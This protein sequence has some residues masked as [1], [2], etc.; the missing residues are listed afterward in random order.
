MTFK[1]MLAVLLSVVQVAGLGLA[2]AAE[3]VGEE[4]IPAEADFAEEEIDTPEEALLIGEEETPAE[5]DG[6]LPAEPDAEAVPDV[7]REDAAE[8]LSGDPNEVVDSGACGDNLTWTL[9]G[10]GLLSIDGTGE[11]RSY[12][13]KHNSSGIY[14]TSAPWGIYF[15]S[16][17]ELRIGEGVTTIGDSAFCGCSGFTGDLVIPDSVTTIESYAFYDCSGFTGSLTIG[18]SVTSIGAY[19]FSGCSGFTGSLTIGNSITTSK[20]EFLSSQ[21]RFVEIMVGRENSSYSS[22]NGMLLNKD[23]T[24]LICCPRGK[25][26]ECV[27]PDRV[28]T[29]GTSAFE[30]CSCLTGSLTI[31]D[32]VTSIGDYAFYN[33]GLTGSLTIP[34]SVTTIGNCAFC[35]CSGF[36]GDL[37]IPDNVTRIGSQAFVNCSGFTG[38]LV[39]PDSV[40]SI[41]SSVFYGCSGFTGTLTIPDSVTTIRDWTFAGCS[42][43]T[44]SLII[45]DSVTSIGSW[46][47][48]RCEGFS[49]SLTVP[50]NLTTIECSAFEGCSGFT[51]DLVIPD[52]VTMIGYSAFSGCSGFTGEL[53]IPDSVTTINDGAFRRCSGFT[54]DL[55]IPDSVTTIGVCAF[56]YCTGFTG[57]LVIPDSVTTIGECAFSCCSGFTGDLVIPNS[58]TKIERQAFECC[59]G[60]TGDLVISDSVTTI[61]ILTFCGCSG[62]T[63]S[64]TIPDSVSS[65]GSNSFAACSGFTGTLTIPD[66]VT[67]I[68]DGAFSG[69]SGFTGSLTIPDSVTS[70]GSSAFYGC[71]GFTGTLTIPDSV[72]T[73]NDGA[74]SGCSGF[75]GSLTIP[76]TVTTIGFDAFSGCSGFTGS[77]V[78]PNGVTTIE[79]YAFYNC[80]G[81]TG[82]L[83]IP[84]SVISIGDS[85]FDKCTGLTDTY[86]LGNAPQS[87]GTSIFGDR[88]NTDFVVRCENEFADS[89]TSDANYDATAGTWYGYPLEIIGMVLPLTVISQPTS[90]EVEPG[91]PVSF[92]VT[93]ARGTAP[94]TYQWQY[95]KPG[96]AAWVN[97]ASA[98][99]KTKTYSLTALL[100]HNGYKYRCRITDA[101]GN[102]VLSGEA[103]LTVREPVDPLTVS[104]QP[105]D[106]TVTPGTTVSFT[107]TAAGGKA[108]YAYQW[109]YQKPGASAWSN[110][111]AASGKTAV[112]TLKTELRHNGY[113]Y[114]CRITDADGSVVYSDTALLTV[115]GPL[116]VAFQPEDRTVLSGQSA[117]FVTAASGGVQP[118]AYQ[119]QYQKPGTDTWTNVTPASGGD[120]SC[121][122]VPKAAARHDGWVIRCR[123][124]DA[125]GTTIYTDL[126]TLTVESGTAPVLTQAPVG[127]SATPGETV[128]FSVRA[129]GQGT[130]S[131]RWQYLKPGASAWVNVS[132]ASGKTQDYSLKVEMRHNGY[133]YR[134]AV[135]SDNGTST[136]SGA[137]YLDVWEEILG[138]GDMLNGFGPVG[139]MQ[140]EDPDFGWDLPVLDLSEKEESL[141]DLGLIS[142]AD[143]FRYADEAE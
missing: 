65:I 94:Y 4:R 20:V 122:T 110:V 113:T 66:S 68:N 23:Q 130:L 40:T 120:T 87:V 47:F 98:S 104:A 69:C 29:I 36:T 85:A 99:G 74:F 7:V 109:Q 112:Y 140:E 136:V 137:V 52:S 103:L 141:W 115:A 80:T 62:F 123:I 11:M 38:D 77:L 13:T 131:Y 75:T 27:I 54:G 43:L 73:I 125:V 45:P 30:S 143:V 142:E 37:V 63:G 49:G 133:R 86:F 26:G 67:T 89:F 1:R 116:T 18:N 79:G 127:V 135:S 118:Y 56:S 119:W 39:I 25:T 59:S 57:K 28:T 46:A 33:C 92:T 78:I 16:L 2:A 17:T 76:D 72:T 111:S 124:R 60:F 14:I 22:S 117:P 42:N 121:F 84:K 19:T 24:K 50:S 41:E 100:R 35:G 96:A 71:S 132:A 6:Y 93:A 44:G 106:Q 139:P 81:F 5:F 21:A 138:A 34:D 15:D 3:G 64:L 134:V 58:V 9:Y 114:R 108:P 90:Q 32:S 31:P 126:V 55:V 95:L 88:Q 102:T 8:P 12:S 51:G 129:E 53:V 10:D 70:I 107:V 48:Y 101:D 91:T 105:V 97:V 128:T 83:E 61:E 82:N